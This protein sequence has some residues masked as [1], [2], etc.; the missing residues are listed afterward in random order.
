MLRGPQIQYDNTRTLSI[1]LSIQGTFWAV[2]W[3]RVLFIT[4]ISAVLLALHKNGALEVC[5]CCDILF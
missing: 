3:I 5:H 1:L 2:I 4:L